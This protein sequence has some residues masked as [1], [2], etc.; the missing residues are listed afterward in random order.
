MN[1]GGFGYLEFDLNEE[2]LGQLLLNRLKKNPYFTEV[3]SIV[4]NN[5]QGNVYLIGGS[6][7]RVL[8]NELFGGT[9][10]SHD[11]DFVVDKLN[12]DLTVPNG[13]DVSYQKFNNPTFKNGELEI[14]IFPLSDYSYIKQNNLK[15]TIENFLAGVPFSIQSMAFDIKKNILLGVDGIIAL[16]NKTIGVHN[17]YSARE[18]AKRKNV[19]INQRMMTKAKSMGFDIIPFDE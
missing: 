4:K 12:S 13:W 5:S 10:L 2:Q 18:V 9:L 17:E 19:S 3:L 11:F 7:S 1:L 15:P 14:D 6:V 8:A 16:K